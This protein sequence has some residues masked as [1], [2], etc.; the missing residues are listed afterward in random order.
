VVQCPAPGSARAHA[1]AP[2]DTP[3]WDGDKVHLPFTSVRRTAPASGIV[4]HDRV[5]RAP[6]PRTGLL[7]KISRSNRERLIG[8]LGGSKA[9]HALEH[10]LKTRFYIDIAAGKPGA[11]RLAIETYV[12]ERLVFASGYPFFQMPAVRRWVEDSLE[13]QAARQIYANRVPGLRRPTPAARV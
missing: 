8:Y 4:T 10:Y 2:T 3:A 13:P 5:L 6:I 7:R 9:R 12:I 11:L 1:G